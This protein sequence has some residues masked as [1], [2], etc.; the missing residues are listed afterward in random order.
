[1]IVLTR[2]PGQSILLEYGNTL[3]LFFLKAINH[4]YYF[5]IYINY[6]LKR[7]YELD[8]N[9]K[10]VFEDDGIEFLFDIRSADKGQFA[11]RIAIDCPDFVHVRRKEL[12]PKI[13]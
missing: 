10:F 1:M 12:Q 13:A 9:T 7:E 3:E 6:V 8:T 11:R 4:K 5:H 2:Y